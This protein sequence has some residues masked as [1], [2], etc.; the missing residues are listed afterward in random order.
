MNRTLK[1]I[2]LAAAFAVSVASAGCAGTTNHKVATEMV[3]DAGYTNVQLTG[4]DYWGCGTGY[5]NVYLGSRIEMTGFTATAPSGRQVK[6]TVCRG[7][8]G[9]YD[10]RMHR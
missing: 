4:F 10:I 6:G 3:E 1:G 7:T 5:E 9:G 8:F 2:G